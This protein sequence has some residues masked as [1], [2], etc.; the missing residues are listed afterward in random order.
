MISKPQINFSEKNQT[1]KMSKALT[2][3]PT[4]TRFIFNEKWNPL[5]EISGADNKW[6]PSTLS[7]RKAVRL[8][9]EEE[10]AKWKKHPNYKSGG[11]HHLVEE[12]HAY[13]RESF[14]NLVRDQNKFSK[15]KETT[16]DVKTFKFFL[17]NLEGHHTGEDKS[18]FVTISKKH[19][20]LKVPLQYLSKDHKHLHP[21]EKKVLEEGDAAAL[22][23]FVDF[24]MDHLNRE[25]LTIVQ[26]MLI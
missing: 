15:K 19:P 12:V 24:L 6:K 14:Q 17:D 2:S 20:E 13:F 8:V 21:L 26:T 11:A 23:E 18:W 25:E 16:V 3:N 5:I 1:Q 7:E 10:L 4:T 9:Y 22:E